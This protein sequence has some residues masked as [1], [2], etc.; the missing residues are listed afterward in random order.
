MKKKIKRLAKGNRNS[1]NFP[2]RNK[3]ILRLCLQRKED[4]LKTHISL[5]NLKETLSIVF[6]LFYF[7][8]ISGN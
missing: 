2:Q 8:A 3:Y 4:I 1:Y 7:N 5:T 6:N